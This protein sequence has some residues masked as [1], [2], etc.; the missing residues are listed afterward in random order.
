[1]R[2]P[3]KTA[4]HAS[5]PRAQ[6]AEPHKVPGSTQVSTKAGGSGL[7]TMARVFVLGLA[8]GGFV[9]YQVASTN[10]RVAAGAILDTYGRAPGD[11]HYLHNHP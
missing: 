2:K 5:P 6:G 11:V 3:K 1:M 4:R 9:G 8:I 7:G 10:S